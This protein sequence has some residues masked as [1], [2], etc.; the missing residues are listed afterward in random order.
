MAVHDW[1][2]D[3]GAEILDR[4][5]HRL[6]PT[7]PTCPNAANSID[8]HQMQRQWSTNRSHGIF[9]EF[10][11]EHDGGKLEMISSMSRVREIE[12]ETEK[13]SKDGVGRPVVFRQYA[14]NRSNMSENVF[15]RPPSLADLG[16]KNRD[17]RPRFTINE[18]PR[19]KDYKD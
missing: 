16:K 5:E 1:A 19:P 15:G 7:I 8:N 18:I 2:C 6:E 11:Y 3:C 9:K 17:G 12:R 10:E 4:Y 14:Q 13:K